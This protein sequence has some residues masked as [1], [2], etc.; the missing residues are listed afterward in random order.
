MSLHKYFGESGGQQH[1]NYKLQWPGT[2]DGF[3]VI[4][5]PNKPDLKQEELENIEEQRDF[6]SEMFTLWDPEQ[7]RIFDQISDRIINGWYRLL[8]RSDHWDEEHKHYRVWL[9]WYQ[10]YG[11]IPPPK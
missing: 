8:K 10:V 11:M 6:K 1:S 4:G 9:E 2:L 5:N 7:K 3:P